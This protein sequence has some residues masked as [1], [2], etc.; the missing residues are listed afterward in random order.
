[1]TAKEAAA[2]GRGKVVLTVTDSNRLEVISF[3]S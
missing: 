2:L 1:M 3:T